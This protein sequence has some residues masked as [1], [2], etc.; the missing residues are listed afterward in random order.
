[1]ANFWIRYGK[2]I[3]IILGLIAV[4]FQ[5]FVTYSIW[6]GHELFWIMMIGQIVLTVIIFLIGYAITTKMLEKNRIIIHR[7]RNR[8][9]FLMAVPLFI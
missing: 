3:T 1:M 4:V 9:L 5:V 2:M 8:H 7:K 6:K